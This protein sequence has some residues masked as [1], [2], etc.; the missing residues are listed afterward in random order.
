MDD[1]TERRAPAHA[2]V[3]TVSALNRA[4][5]QLLEDGLGTVAVV[6]EISNLARPQSGHLYFSLKDERA[7]LRCAFFRQRQRGLAFKPGNGDEVIVTGAVSLYE[8]R[9]DYQLIVHRME[10]AGA[11][12]LQQRFEALKRKLA[13]EGLF[14]D[15]HKSP[16]PRFPERI[17]VVTSPSGAAIRDILNVLGR[18]FPRAAVRIYPVQVQGTAA[19]A[20]IAATLTIAGERADCDVLILARGGGSLEDLWAFNEEVVA[21]A[22][23]DCPLPVIAGVGHETD[24]TIADFVA[25]VRAP[26]PS[27]AAEL[28]VPD[29][30]ELAALL[31]STRERLFESLGR[32]LERLQQRAD[33]AQR[34]LRALSPAYALD[35]RRQRLLGAQRALAAAMERTLRARSERGRAL[36]GRLARLSPQSAVSERS[37]AL[38]ELAARL[39]TAA[40]RR[41]GALRQRLTVAERTLGAVSPLATLAR[42]YAIATDA[43]GHL[44]REAT[45]TLLG[46]PLM[47][48]VERGSLKTRVESVD[49]D[50]N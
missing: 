38:R 27:G 19:P 46:H 18:R 11:G 2:E 16:L 15:I 37:A 12:A 30:L 35:N 3:Q 49:D 48:R 23:F 40:E 22:V 33:W 20:D 29:Q 43:N 42:G 6:G 10:V 50:D 44:I 8:P 34:Q 24:V 14:E 32:R 41:L 31:G 39:A 4:A 45:E 36:A 9:G 7:Q 25:D 13:A 21:R 26:T 1:P 17:G 5:R 28:A 47:V